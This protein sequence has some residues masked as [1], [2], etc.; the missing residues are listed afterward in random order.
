MLQVDGQTLDCAVVALPVAVLFTF[1]EVG[2]CAVAEGVVKLLLVE[3][4]SGVGNVD[5]YFD[6]GVHLY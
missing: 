3:I 6:C 2:F 1:F 4:L 5:S